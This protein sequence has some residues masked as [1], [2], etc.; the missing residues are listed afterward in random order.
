MPENS[1]AYRTDASGRILLE[2]TSRQEIWRCQCCGHNGTR[3]KISFNPLLVGITRKIFEHCVKTR[4]FEFDRRDLQGFTTTE[5][6]NMALLQRFGILYRPTDSE[7][8]RISRGKWGMP[9]KRVRAFLSGKWKV[10]EHFWR[11][12]DAEENEQSERRVTVFEIK[13]A[14]KFLDPETLLPAFLEYDKLE[15]GGN[16]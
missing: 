8:R 13:G 5:Y 15:A 10:A 6:N 1:S 16:F 14:G 2:K 12:G 9:V 3:Y 7:G 11:D 4:S